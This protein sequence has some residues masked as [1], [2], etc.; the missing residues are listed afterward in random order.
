M[1]D[2]P[3]D[4]SSRLRAAWDE[5][6]AWM[7]RRRPALRRGTDALRI[8]GALAALGL[9]LAEVGF[10]HDAARHVALL[11]AGRALLVAMTALF[12]VRAAL[13]PK[14]G[15]FLQQYATE[16]GLLGVVLLALGGIY[17]VEGELQ[18]EAFDVRTSAY[19]WLIDGGLLVVVGYVA[20]ERVNRLTRLPVRPATALVGLFGA[21]IALGTLLLWLPEATTQPGS[22]PVLDALFTATSAVC[23]T[24]LVVVPTGEAFTGLGQGVILGLI[25]LGGLGVLSTATAIA[26]LFG[27]GDP[28]GTRAMLKDIQDAQTLGEVQS[29]LRQIVLVTLGIEAAGAVAIFAAADLPAEMGLG[30]RLYFAIFHAVSAFCNA[31]FSTAPGSLTGPAL[32]TDVGLNLAF[33]ALIVLG[34]V[35]FVVL[36]DTG[37]VLHR[38][39][40]GDT[41]VTWQTWRHGYAVQARL[42]WVTSGALLALGFAAFLALEQGATLARFDTTAERLLASAFQSVTARTAGFSTVDV[43]AVSPAMAVVFI[44]LMFVGASPGSTGGGIKTS[45]LA[46]CL[47]FLR[48]QLRGHARVDVCGRTIA[49]R[50]MQRAVAVVFFALAVTSVSTVALLVTEAGQPVLDV[51]FEAVS[52]F[53]TVGLSRGLTPELSAPGKGIVVANM[54]LGR[55]GVLALAVFLASQARRRPYAF[56]ETTVMVA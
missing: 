5:A 47:R 41:Q 45:T 11:K 52:A 22:L 25:Q 43:G 36:R 4:A 37:A 6:R 55:V 19:R 54:F 14:R 26:T 8:A 51:W 38:G 18:L 12:G 32:A 17:L 1:P 2:D 10:P 21:A 24:G 53:G 7:R 50:T 23:V 13:A 15:P 29:L 46:L 30:G 28:V 33:M 56:P 49:R 40:R 35:G 9:L 3:A 42:V 31:G 48:A 34:G 39:A 27:G 16:A 44:G 20:G